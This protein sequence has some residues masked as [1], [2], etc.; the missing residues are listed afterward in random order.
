MVQLAFSKPPVKKVTTPSH[1][2]DYVIRLGD[3]RTPIPQMKVNPELDGIYLRRDGGNTMDADLQFSKPPDQTTDLF[4][5]R[6]H[7]GTLGRVEN[8]KT[9]AL[10]KATDATSKEYC[11]NNFFWVD[12]SK[13][14]KGN[15][16]FAPAA[17]QATQS[18]EI[19]FHGKGYF[20][21]EDIGRLQ[22]QKDG[23]IDCTPG[24][25]NILGLAKP[26]GNNHAANK[27]YVD[28]SSLSVEGNNTMKSNLQMKDALGNEYF[29]EGSKDFPEYVK[30][31][32]S[33]DEPPQERLKWDSTCV[34]RATV[35][36]WIEENEQ[37]SFSPE[38]PCK[39][40]I[41]GHICKP[42]FPKVPPIYFPIEKNEEEE[43]VTNVG[44]VRGFFNAYETY[45][46]RRINNLQ[47]NIFNE[48]QNVKTE[49]TNNETDISGIKKSVANRLA[50]PFLGADI[51]FDV[52]LCDGTE[53]DALPGISNGKQRFWAKVPI[54]EKATLDPPTNLQVWN[55]DQRGKRSEYVVISN[56]ED[57][58]NKLSEGTNR[59]QNSYID[60]YTIFN[61]PYVDQTYI[62]LYDYLKTYPS[63]FFRRIV[64]P[65]PGSPDRWAFHGNLVTAFCV[66]ESD[67]ALGD[68]QTSFRMDII[69]RRQPQA[70][71][72][73]LL[74]V[75]VEGSWTRQRPSNQWY[76][77]LYGGNDLHKI[78]GIRIPKRPTEG[79]VNVI[80]LHFEPASHSL[81]VNCSVCSDLMSPQNQFIEIAGNIPTLPLSVQP[82]TRIIFYNAAILG[83]RFFK[84]DETFSA[85]TR[86]YD[87]IS[88]AAALKWFHGS[89]WVTTAY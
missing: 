42:Q 17:E 31:D 66:P 85:T 4:N 13:E 69:A 10:S 8:L 53:V 87:A 83:Q 59:R 81:H 70:S 80:A 63:P 6:F 57:E 71:D 12:G 19:V 55:D 3:Y 9:D 76:I 79:K 49:I 41:I 40:P 28:Q 26:T 67:N 23:L 30:L 82:D 46:D 72:I 48:L 56:G 88:K 21:F 54:L 58:D 11:D 34:N 27:L 29:V 24:T 65:S 43:W 38:N 78:S 37:D 62:L 64:N 33:D 50:F 86:K 61:N 36:R 73:I 16:I 35:R 68:S 47:Q 89:T 25:L 75:R 51:C 1:V 74:S 60:Q 44:Y 39:L 7:D 18:R 77:N 32:Y 20:G 5:L 2:V 14:M 15:I 84:H 22:F 45:I 52:R